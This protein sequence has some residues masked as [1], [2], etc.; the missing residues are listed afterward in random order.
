L[1][2]GCPASSVVK[3]PE[4]PCRGTSGFSVEMRL[5]RTSAQS[6]RRNS[7]YP[8][9]YRRPLYLLG[10]PIPCQEFRTSTAWKTFRR[11]FHAMEK[12][13]HAMENFFHT[14]E[15][16]D[17]R[18]RSTVGLGRKP[19]NAAMQELTLPAL[20][21]LAPL[22][23]FALHGCSIRGCFWRFQMRLLC[24]LPRLTSPPRCRYGP[25]YGK[26]S[27]GFA[28][29]RSQVQS[30]PWPDR[31]DSEIP[32]GRIAIARRSN[33]PLALTLNSPRME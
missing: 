5:A 29:A 3:N 23:P 20:A 24:A 18:R 10:F 15:V 27:G 11:F 30:L 7:F 25:G 19:E 33:T 13:I 9:S 26:C 16:P 17:F 1:R 8:P 14:V 6:P 12:V 28:S 32:V 2:L 31:Q 21:S 22:A 4:L